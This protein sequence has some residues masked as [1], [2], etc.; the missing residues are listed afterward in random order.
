MKIPA[1][2]GHGPVVVHVA[3]LEDEGESALARLREILCR[4]VP[5][6]GG[7]VQHRLLGKVEHLAGEGRQVAIVRMKKKNIIGG[8]HTRITLVRSVKFT[9][10]V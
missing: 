10:S 7:G 5:Q 9:V 1:C 2:V 3:Y 8:E 6:R 4:V